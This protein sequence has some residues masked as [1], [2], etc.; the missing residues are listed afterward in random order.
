MWVIEVY[1]LSLWVSWIRENS[2]FFLLMF[3]LGTWKDELLSWSKFIEKICDSLT[4][5]LNC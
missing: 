4:L 2:L 1:S 5:C 3:W